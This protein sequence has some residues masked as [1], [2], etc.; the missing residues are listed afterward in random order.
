MPATQMTHHMWRVTLLK[1]GAMVYVNVNFSNA[2]GVPERWAVGTLVGTAQR[3][4]LCRVMFDD[5]GDHDFAGT[6]NV[7][8]SFRVKR[9]RY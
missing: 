7:I 5:T 3:G 4:R 9:A 2:P 1:R 6:T 8:A